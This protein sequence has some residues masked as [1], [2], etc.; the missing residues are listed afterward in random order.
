MKTN[1]A[2]ILLP[3]FLAMTVAGCAAQDGAGGEMVGDGRTCLYVPNISGFS[4]L[5]DREVLVTVGVND[6]YLFT[7]VGVCSGLRY[8]NAIL[9]ADS[10]GSRI[11]NDGFGRIAFRQAGLGRQTCRVGNIE[12][13]TSR[14]EAREIVAARE[15]A[16]RE[17]TED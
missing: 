5:S 10:S 16:R 11:C 7:V 6:H 12:R 1:L 2:S 13:V 17:R 14:E 4:S 8:A 3:T 15:Q 9:V